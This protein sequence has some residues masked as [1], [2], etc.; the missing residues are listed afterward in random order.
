MYYNRIFQNVKFIPNQTVTGP[1]HRNSCHV[2]DLISQ[3]CVCVCVLTS[4]DLD[5]SDHY[6]EYQS[7]EL[8]N[9]ENILDPCRP[10]HTG[11][12]HPGQ[13]HCRNAQT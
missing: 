5:D 8:S 1:N 9:S 12:V 2:E 4:T 13:E 10:A 7:E 3:E 11:A 6:D